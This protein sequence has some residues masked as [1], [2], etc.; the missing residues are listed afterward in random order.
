[1]SNGKDKFVPNG[2][3]LLCLACMNVNV[4]SIVS[5]LSE[6]ELYVLEENPDI[7]VLIE[8]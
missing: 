8:S 2:S 6:F 4:W 5:K 7:I 1:M 3:K